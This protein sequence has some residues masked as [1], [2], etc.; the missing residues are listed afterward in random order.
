MEEAA[1]KGVLFDWT[2]SSY[3]LRYDFALLETRLAALVL[4]G[5]GKSALCE[6][7]Q[8]TELAFSGVVI[9]GIQNARVLG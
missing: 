8:G 7:C 6:L 5:L 2:L 9:M 4:P 1:A 3:W